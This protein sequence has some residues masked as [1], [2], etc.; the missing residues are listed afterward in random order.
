MVNVRHVP[1]KIRIFSRFSAYYVTKIQERPWKQSV[2]IRNLW[3]FL[4]DN[5][6]YF[7]CLA[8]TWLPLTRKQSLVVYVGLKMKMTYRPYPPT[9]MTTDC[10]I[11]GEK[12]KVFENITKFQRPLTRLQ[13]LSSASFTENLSA[14]ILQ[15]YTSEV[16]FEKWKKFATRLPFCWFKPEIESFW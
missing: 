3:M 10:L 8:A 11:L 6:P 15:K 1:W 5:C 2:Y 13:K 7:L 14:L 12:V 4:N 16:S 9:C